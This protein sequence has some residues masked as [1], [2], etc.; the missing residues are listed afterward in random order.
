MRVLIV[1]SARARARVRAALGDADIDIVGEADS[2][3]VARASSIEVD[4]Y[5]VARDDPF[6]DDDDDADGIA[7]E[8][9]TRDDDDLG[10]LAV[11]HDRDGRGHADVSVGE[12]T[13]KIVDA[14]NRFAVERHDQIARAQT[15]DFRRARWFHRSHENAAAR[16]GALR[17]ISR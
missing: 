8:P 15:G 9:L 4:G 14:G 16:G 13:M 17:A 7:L 12:V 5:L 3:A 11:A 10:R 6:A 1:G 2:L